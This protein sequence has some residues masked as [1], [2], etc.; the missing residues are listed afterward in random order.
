[1]MYVIV[2]LCVMCI[3]DKDLHIKNRLAQKYEEK[4][5]LGLVPFVTTPLKGSFIVFY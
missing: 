1:M 3:K 5:F 4:N 2:P